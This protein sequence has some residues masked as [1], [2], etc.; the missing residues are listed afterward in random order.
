MGKS[1]TNTSEAQT[2]TC[3]GNCLYTARSAP[4]GHMQSQVT[5]WE[6]QIQILMHF[7]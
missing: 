7:D 3:E 1:T 5:A 2:A 4:T 6:A